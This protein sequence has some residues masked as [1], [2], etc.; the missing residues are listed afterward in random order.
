MSDKLKCKICGKVKDLRAFSYVN[1]ELVCSKS[2]K[3]IV[4][5]WED[6]KVLRDWDLE[7]RIKNTNKQ[8]F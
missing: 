7:Q 6:S 8:T 5:K 1:G 2:C 4:E 3:K